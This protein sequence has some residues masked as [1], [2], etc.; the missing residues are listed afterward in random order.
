MGWVE[1]NRSHVY[2]KIVHGKYDSDI[3]VKDQS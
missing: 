3:R 1:W 2:R